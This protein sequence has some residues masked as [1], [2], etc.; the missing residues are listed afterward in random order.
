MLCNMPVALALVFTMAT[1]G[2]DQTDRSSMGDCVAFTLWPPSIMVM[3]VYQASVRSALCVVLIYPS[4]ETCLSCHR[5]SR[6]FCGQLLTGTDP[7]AIQLE[8]AMGC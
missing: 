2:N 6:S 4:P 3:A 8:Q 7:S 1:T 5:S